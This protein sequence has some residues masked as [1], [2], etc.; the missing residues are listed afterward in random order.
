MNLF[1][2]SEDA[3][4]AAFDYVERPGFFDRSMV[5][6]S[7]YS[8]QY[9]IERVTDPILTTGAWCVSTVYGDG[10]WNRYFVYRD[11]TIMFSRSHAERGCISRAVTAGFAI[12]D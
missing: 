12:F 6:N 7:E 4:R 9:A 10:G 5:E 2:T 3:L 8:I 11:G 1:T